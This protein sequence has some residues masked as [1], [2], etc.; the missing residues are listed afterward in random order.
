MDHE[1]VDDRCGSHGDGKKSQ[2]SAR[3]EGKENQSAAS[4]F[5]DSS[6]VAEPLADS[7]LIEKLDPMTFRTGWELLESEEHED[8]PDAGTKDPVADFVGSVV[9]CRLFK[10]G[11]GRAE[12]LS[13]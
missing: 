2:A 13:M 3:S 12:S 6:E 10:H 1:D 5:N 4:D 11:E 8:E 9:G 7:D